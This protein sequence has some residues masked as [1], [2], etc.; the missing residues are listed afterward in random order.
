MA[1]AGGIRGFF[2]DWFGKNLCILGPAAS[3]KSLYW[4][5]LTEQ[6]SQGD[7]DKHTATSYQ[8][9]EQCTFKVNGKEIWLS[10]S[11]DVGGR[12]I[13]RKKWKALYKKSDIAIYL[14]DG[15]KLYKKDEDYI[16]DVKNDL[17]DI[18]EWR[19]N[20]KKKTKLIIIITWCDLIKAYKDRIPMTLEDDN[21][22]T[23]FP[24]LHIK[25]YARSAHIVAG[26]ALDDKLREETLALALQA[27]E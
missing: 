23:D 27:I 12:I 5:Y 14:A 22:R 13:F 2:V 25:K 10:R 15:H 17:E 18:Y 4:K 8:E 20:F 6:L 21:L 24:P 3:G 16:E 9:I 7:K 1:K 19:K 26:T 11:T